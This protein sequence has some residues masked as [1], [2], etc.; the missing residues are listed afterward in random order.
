MTI[1]VID[2][3]FKNLLFICL[4]L[5]QT[6]K[7]NAYFTVNFILIN[8][9]CFILNIIS[10]LKNLSLLVNKSKRFFYISNKK[11]NKE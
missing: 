4:I 2:D 10:M 5:S 11:K 1:Q 7:F 9:I 6:S 3:D 8:C